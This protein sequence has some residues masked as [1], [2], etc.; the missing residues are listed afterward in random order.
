MERSYSINIK[1]FENPVD[2]VST[3]S[4]LYS[5]T[6]EEKYINHIDN[7]FDDEES[8]LELF[9]W[10]NGTGNVIHKSKLKGVLNYWDKIDVL[11][12]LKQ[13]FSWES[14][15]KEFEPQKSSTIWRIFL[16]HLINPKEFPI[17]DQHVSRF[18]H[19]QKSGLIQELPTNPNK[20][21]LIYKLE[22]KDWFSRIQQKYNLQHKEMDESFFMYGRM[23][24]K[25]NGLPI[26]IRG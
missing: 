11:R 5:Y 23:L 14:F 13:E 8:F 3:W 1:G 10:K 4:N 25:L 17:F 21:Y 24:K 12:K 6:I 20:I 7:V 9:K 18:Y 22:Y 19:F 26:Q 16:L 2:F 15:E